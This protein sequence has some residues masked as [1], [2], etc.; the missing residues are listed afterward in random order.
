MREARTKPVRVALGIFA[1]GLALWPLTPASAGVAPPNLGGDL[2]LGDIDFAADPPSDFDPDLSAVPSDEALVALAEAIPPAALQAI[3]MGANFLDAD[4]DGLPDEGEP[5]D[6]DLRPGETSLADLATALEGGALPDDIAAVAGANPDIPGPDP[7]EVVGG[8]SQLQGQ[9]AGVAISYDGDGAVIDAAVGIGGGGDG[10][11]IDTHG[12]GA[13]QRAFTSA[14]RFEVRADGKVVYFGYLPYGGGD[15]ARNHT[16][17]IKTGSLSVD[18]GGDDNPQG[19]N[20]NAGV[21][22]LGGNIPG[23]LRFTG[24]MSVTGE[25]FSQN[26]LWCV[27]KGHVHFGGGFPPVAGGIAAVFAA[28]GVLGLLFNSRPAMT[29]KV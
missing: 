6:L 4:G 20:A 27:A 13:G 3:L 2:E 29:Y 8:G 15:G 18:S 11:L 9:C 17:T 12:S 14:N 10:L 26:G 21:V 7:D 19:N 22:D 5:G 28:G 1:A 23:P 16:W 25:L 24:N